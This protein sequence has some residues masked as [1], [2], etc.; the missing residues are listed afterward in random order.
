MTL[1]P[2]LAAGPKEYKGSGV[3]HEGETF[4]GAVRVQCLLDGKGVLLHYEV[5]VADHEVV[6]AECTL[7]A[8]DMNGTL[9]L[10]P[11]MFELPGVLSHRAIAQSKTE[12]KFA[13]EN[14]DDK[15]EFREEITILVS[16][17]GSL[18]Y[19]HARG[20][21]GGQFEDRSSCRLWPSDA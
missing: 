16:A 14:R 10:W 13:S 2:V 7:L 5:K 19:A 15:N 9:M 3:N 6:S 20:L 8:P 21:P 12:D 17:D 4:V 11:L 1:L 18:T